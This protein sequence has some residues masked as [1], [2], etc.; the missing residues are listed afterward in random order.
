MTDK[1]LSDEEVYD[2][3]H[4]AYLALGKESA[5]TVVGH[6]SIE[7]ARQ[8]L[9]ALQMGLLMAIESGDNRNGAIIDPSKIP[10]P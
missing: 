1:T 3:M 7:T 9:Q 5:A 10:P 4:A 8:A 2:R 6:T